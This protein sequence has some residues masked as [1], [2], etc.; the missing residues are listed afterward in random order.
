MHPGVGAVVSGYL[1]HLPEREIGS[2]SSIPVEDEGA[3]HIHLKEFR[4]SLKFENPVV[5]LSGG[6][7]DGLSRLREDIVKG[8]VFAPNC[9]GDESEDDEAA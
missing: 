7:E 1:R 3:L 2:E 8:G 4:G 6:S 9:A 5:G